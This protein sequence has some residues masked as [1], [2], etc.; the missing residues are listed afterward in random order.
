MK[1]A[2]VDDTALAAP[3]EGGRSVLDTDASAVAKA[4]ILHQEQ[5]YDG[6]TILRPIVY[7]SE[8]LTQTQ[9]IH[10]APKLEQFAVL[11]F[12]ENIYSYLAG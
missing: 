11:Y 3:N 9:L 4:G 2:L 7:G 10:Y 6:K 12:I 1:Q 8:S 5:E